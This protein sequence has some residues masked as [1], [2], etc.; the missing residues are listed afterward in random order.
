[1]GVTVWSQVSLLKKT[2]DFVVDFA[3]I[4]A[5]TRQAHEGYV[6]P[7]CKNESRHAKKAVRDAEKNLENAG[8]RRTCRIGGPRCKNLCLEPNGNQIVKK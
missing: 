3:W 6:W 2:Q 8:V 5:V 1:M 7:T 4:R